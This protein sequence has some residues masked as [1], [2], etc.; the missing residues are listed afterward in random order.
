MARYVVTHLKTGH[1]VRP[2][3]IITDNTGTDAY[4]VM[5]VGNPPPAQI[6]VTEDNATLQSP[7]SARYAV[8]FNLDVTEVP[9]SLAFW[10]GDEHR[11][12]VRLD[13][14]RSVELFPDGRL[15]IYSHDRMHGSEIIIP[16]DIE[17]G[18]TIDVP[19]RRFEPKP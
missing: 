1:V 10:S 12:L 2:G 19:T 4:F 8:D 6:I 17:W 7:A 11:V 16:D 13:D 5:V 15:R 18:G 9:N 14:G 3:D